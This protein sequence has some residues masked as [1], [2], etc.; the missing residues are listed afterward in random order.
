MNAPDRLP[1]VDE[2]MLERALTLAE[3]SHWETDAAKASALREHAL[4]LWAHA[5]EARR[6]AMYERGRPH[7]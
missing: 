7:D 2:Q 5:H 3:A 6:R 4:L 1:P